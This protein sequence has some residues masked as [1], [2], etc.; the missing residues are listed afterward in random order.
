ME[1]GIEAGLVTVLLLILVLALT[2]TFAGREQDEVE[3]T[4]QEW[5]DYSPECS[6]FSPSPAPGRTR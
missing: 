3:C 4:A 5:A 2:G 6:R 1:K